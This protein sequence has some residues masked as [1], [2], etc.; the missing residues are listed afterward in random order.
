MPEV[1]QEISSQMIGLKAGHTYY[2]Q[3]AFECILI[4]SILDVLFEIPN[5]KILSLTF[6]EGP[7][8][9]SFCDQGILGDVGNVQALSEIL[10]DNHY[11]AFGRR[12]V[13]FVK[14]S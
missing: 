13:G 11:R 7:L 9:Q 12:N 4:S 2:H 8:N 5:E 1:C 6:D 10:A 3:L 14:L